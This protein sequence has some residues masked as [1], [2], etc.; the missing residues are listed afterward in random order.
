MTLPLPLPSQE[1]QGFRDAQ[2]Q[3]VGKTSFSLSDQRTGG[4]QATKKGQLGLL[5][6]VAVTLLLFAFLFKSLSW[7]TLWTTLLHA[8]RVM[9]LVGLLVGA[10]GIV[11]SSAQWQSLLKAERITMRLLRLT[12]LYLV[13]I[14]FSHF[15]PTSMGGDAI[16][17]FYVSRE[18]GNGAGAVS[19]V[20][21]SR[22]TGFFGMLLIALPVLVIWFSQF[23]PLVRLWFLLLS[24]LVGGM[25][26][27]AIYLT[28]FVAKIS[29]LRLVKKY[30]LVLRVFAMV[31]R[32]GDALRMSI[33]RPRFLAAA[34]LLG[35]L[36]W[37]T[38][39]LNYYSYARA[40][41]IQVPLYFYFVAIPFVSLLTFLPISINGFGIREGAFV[42]I[43]ST[44]HIALATS[45]LLAFLIDAQVLLFGV[46]GGYFYLTMSS[47][48]HV[49][50]QS[51]HV[52]SMRS[53][54]N[55]YKQ[56]EQNMHDTQP[57]LQSVGPLLKEPIHPSQPTSSLT[58]A[59]VSVD[60][61]GV[62]QEQQEHT[63]L[64]QPKSPLLRPTPMPPQD[65]WQR[66][67]ALLKRKRRW[68][69]TLGAA[70]CL[71]VLLGTFGLYETT[72]GS[73]N[74]TVYQAGVQNVSQSIGGGGIVYPLQKMDISYPNTERVTNVFVK[75]GDQVTA[76]QPLLQLDTGQLN[77]EIAQAAD[78]LAA[79]QVYYNDVLASGNPV[80]IAQ[81][82]QAYNL[83]KNKY[84]A[85]IAQT[86][87]NIQ[88][89]AIISPI[90]GVVVAVNV[91]PGEVITGNTPF[92]TIEDESKVVVH[93]K[94]PL[95]NLQQVH[96]GQTAVVTPSALP[97]LNFSGVVTA[98]IPQADPQTDTFEV[99]VQVVNTDKT[100]LPGM[101]AFV[102]I[103]NA[104]K[105]VVLPRLAV[106]NSDRESA[107]FVVRNQHAYIQH[108]H[109][110][111]RSANVVFVD[112]GIS[113]G[114]KVVVVGANTLQNGQEVH[115]K[116][117][118]GQS[119]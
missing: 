47:K 43:F 19:G 72:Q 76:K 114:D 84:D 56:A 30:A 115:I 10:L 39:C 75:A 40:L 11:L 90:T 101:S 88:N 44:V 106:L 99:W 17:A 98:I 46:I 6:R 36:F 22:I 66:L 3:H 93:V 74:V 111:G 31:I 1:S 116:H 20:V 45:L 7:S 79:A 4:R 50:K 59:Q 13:G 118:E 94:V 78:D 119:A 108:V 80:T 48:A 5:L 69:I 100:L 57:R 61:A 82:K 73:S 102:R 89:G 16:K 24:L 23:T 58:R 67:F 91:N 85:L 49:T 110:V 32:V 105:A 12:R 62:E 117:V 26:C 107:V 86:S 42:Y 92:L 68:T 38:G 9:L 34:T 35:M 87:P 95:S 52:D 37:I 21:M 113:S 103:E 14:A 96:L 81:A 104:G 83:A 97:N 33:R 51:E 15:L 54:M 55:E 77:A 25:I 63:V 27:G 28:S 109:V 64:H 70:I 41:H 71:L 60:A 29:E 65:R 112:S 2:G 18:A 53:I 8:D